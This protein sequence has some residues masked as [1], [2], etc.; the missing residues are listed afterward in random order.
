MSYFFFLF[1]GAELM[2]K[3][4]LTAAATPTHTPIS[5]PALTVTKLRTMVKQANAELCHG[6]VNSDYV[7]EAL[8]TNTIVVGLLELVGHTRTLKSGTRV[9]YEPELR[10]F[11]LASETAD[12]GIYLDIICAH[13][14]G[15][16]MLKQFVEYAEVMKGSKYVELN[17]LPN[18]LG[19]YPRYGFQHRHTCSESSPIA[20][21]DELTQYIRTHKPMA[22]VSYTHQPIMEYML[23]LHAMGFTAKMTPECQTVALTPDGFRVANCAENGFKMRKC[24]GVAGG[25]RRPLTRRHRRSGPN[26]NM[27]KHTRSQR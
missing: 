21:R 27:H 14:F 17:A 11:I 8:K 12:G 25:G 24:F 20:I 5:A 4:P 23:Q 2:L 26:K 22:D 10:G 9:N 7:A 16:E 15:G 1:D 18:V 19:F 13:V 3:K 6:I